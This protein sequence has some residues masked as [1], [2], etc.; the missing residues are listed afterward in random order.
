MPR[1]GGGIPLTAAGNPAL[2]FAARGGWRFFG[3]G[4]AVWLRLGGGLGWAGGRRGVSCGV[5]SGCA[6]FVPAGCFVGAF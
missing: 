4:V 2:Q 6:L 5:G 1:L 3:G